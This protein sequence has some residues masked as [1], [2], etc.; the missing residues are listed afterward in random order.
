M[1]RAYKEKK[2]VISKSVFIADS[3]DVIGDVTVGEYSSIW[4]NT[5]VRGD[6]N[7]INIGK[8][9]NIQDNSVLHVTKDIYPLNIGN[10]VT[11]GHRV[12]AHG[13]TINDRALIGIGSILLDGSIVQEL[14]IVGAGSLVPPGFIVPSGKLVVG[15]PCSVKRDLSKQEIEMI[16]QLSKNYVEYS[17]NYTTNQI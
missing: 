10:E 2:P 12:V 7:Y 11:V 8:K 16:Y 4:F 14:S 9:T 15:V 6:V 1:L 17:K 13:C 5:V 3:A